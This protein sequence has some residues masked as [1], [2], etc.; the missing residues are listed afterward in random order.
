[1]YI[2]TKKITLDNQEVNAEL[3]YFEETDKQKIK[4]IYTSALEKKGTKLEPKWAK[5]CK[6]RD[7]P[8][9]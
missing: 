9:A 5:L 8:A 2:K 4:E 1:M 6:N 7:D 3:Q